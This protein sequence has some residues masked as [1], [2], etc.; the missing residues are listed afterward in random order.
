MRSKFDEYEHLFMLLQW[1][2]ANIMIRI[3]GD[4]RLKVW[5]KSIESHLLC[6]ESEIY[7]EHKSN[8]SK[9]E[10]W[11]EHW[12]EHQK[13]MVVVKL[14]L[15]FKIEWCKMNWCYISTI[16]IVKVTAHWA[17]PVSTL[18]QRCFFVYIDSSNTI[19]FIKLASAN[20][21][22]YAYQSINN[23]FGSMVTWVV[24]FSLHHFV[25]GS[26]L[27]RIFIAFWLIAP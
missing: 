9:S 13:S 4:L 27:F 7:F 26:S 12:S 23:H 15:I 8:V 6:I 16:L 24:P 20:P 14:N 11:S 22:I 21:L 19:I 1:N 2:L 5:V 18:N 10:H 3:S 25:V 17:N